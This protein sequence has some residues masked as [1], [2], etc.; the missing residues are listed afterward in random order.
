MIIQPLPVYFFC[1]HCQVI[2]YCPSEINW[3]RTLSSTW[4]PLGV[5]CLRDL[6]QSPVDIDVG[7]P[8]AVIFDQFRQVVKV[9]HVGY[10]ISTLYMYRNHSLCQ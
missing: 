4:F 2:Y 5:M 7:E 10:N 1:S 8:F 3:C 6:V 9:S